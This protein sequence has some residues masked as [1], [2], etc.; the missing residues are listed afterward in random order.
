MFLGRPLYPFSFRTPENQY[1]AALQ[2]YG[3]EEVHPDTVDDKESADAWTTA[4]DFLNDTSTW[5]AL[6]SNLQLLSDTYGLT[7]FDVEGAEIWDSGTAYAEDDVVLQGFKIYKC[8]NV[9]GSTGDNPA[10]DGGSNWEQI[11]PETE[12]WGRDSLDEWDSSTTYDEGDEVYRNMTKFVSSQGSNLDNDPYTDTD[13]TYWVASGSVDVFKPF[14]QTLTDRFLDTTTPGWKFT[15]LPGNN[16]IEGANLEYIEFATL[17]DAVGIF[18]LYAGKIRLRLSS[19]SEGEIIFDETV[20]MVDDG[21]MDDW[22]DYFFGDV[23]LFKEHIFTNL[24]QYDLNDVVYEAW[25]VAPGTSTGIA[26]GSIQL[27]ASS[28]LGGTV[29]GTSLTYKDHSV[30]TTD[31]FGNTDFTVRPVS[32]IVDYDFVMDTA[33]IRYAR[34]LI[35]DNRAKN[36]VFY[37]VDDNQVTGT[38]VFGRIARELEINISGP[39]KSRATLSVESLAT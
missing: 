2:I 19:V 8:V 24:P 1:P 34:T 3:V 39:N 22:Y 29:Y 15:V 32:L 13:G 31:Q 21:V 9:S 23:R 33:A 38:L 12:F 4:H 37:A 25:I 30:K 18:N 17:V 16:Y 35:T 6:N 10:S 14:N 27:V 28:Q 36:A 7:H 5:K 11:A 20:S 26:V